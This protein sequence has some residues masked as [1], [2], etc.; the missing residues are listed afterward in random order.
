[1]PSGLGLPG[2]VLESRKA[3]WI[4]DVTVDGNFPRAQV[5]VD[6]G[7][8]SGFGVPIWVRDEVVGVLEFFQ[9][10]PSEPDEELMHE[11]VSVGHQIGRVV[12]RE[13]VRTILE[14]S[15]QR[16][17]AAAASAGD[18]IVSADSTGSI[19][20]F[21]VAAEEMFGR[22]TAEV[23]G[24]ELTILM[25]DRYHTPH[26]TGFNRFLTTREE[27]VIGKTVELAGR[28]KDGTEFPLEL[29]LAT[30]DVDGESFFTGIIRDVTERRE[31]E[32]F[33]RQ[34][35]VA[36]LSQQQALELND[37]VVQGLAAAKLALDIGQEDRAATLVERTL[38]SARAI[39]SGLLRD[40]EKEK[41]LKP[42][43]LVREKP[44]TL[45]RTR[46]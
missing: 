6:L 28:R 35:E 43:D 11:M 40:A 31:A 38:S 20:Y 37:N 41:R 4:A 8:R 16:F 30:W 39:I 14:E 27:R 42:G 7:I 12:E 15:E 3:I 19:I 45:D 36:L 46:T 1:M 22:S 9:E 18:A 32:I 24:K 29:S 10:T 13:R 26:R 21:N 25:P 23:L 17:K 34:L 33:R 2:R 44:A 5:S